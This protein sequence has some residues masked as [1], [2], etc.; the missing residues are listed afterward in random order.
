VIVHNIVYR[1]TASSG[2]GLGERP[3]AI[4]TGDFEVQGLKP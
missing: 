2:Y 1:E 3:F 4:L